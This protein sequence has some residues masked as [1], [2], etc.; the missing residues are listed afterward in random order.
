MICTLLLLS[1]FVVLFIVTRLVSRNVYE[2]E[3]FRPEE[4]FSCKFYFIFLHILDVE[5]KITK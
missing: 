4:D 1:L 2:S 5:L 3:Q